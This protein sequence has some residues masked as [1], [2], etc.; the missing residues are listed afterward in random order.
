MSVNAVLIIMYPSSVIMASWNSM[1]ANKY[2]E[3]IID[4]FDLYQITRRDKT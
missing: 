3:K 2:R 1:H 4:N